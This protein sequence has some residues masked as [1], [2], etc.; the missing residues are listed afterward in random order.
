MS[1]Y[2]ETLL[3]NITI[4]VNSPPPK[5]PSSEI[6]AEVFEPIYYTNA[7]TLPISKDDTKS[8]IST[9]SKRTGFNK[10]LIKKYANRGTDPLTPKKEY[11]FSNYFVNSLPGLLPKLANLGNLDQAS[12]GYLQSF[13]DFPSG[14]YLPPLHSIISTPYFPTASYRHC[15][16]VLNSSL[17]INPN[18]T[19]YLW[20]SI[21]EI[22]DDRTG[23]SVN[24]LQPRPDGAVV[25]TSQPRSAPNPR[26]PIWLYPTTYERTIN[27]NNGQEINAFSLVFSIVPGCEENQNQASPWSITIQFGEVTLLINEG[28]PEVKITIGSNEPMNMTIQP[29]AAGIFTHHFGER[30]Y[31]LTFIPVWNGLIISDA[32]PGS[33]NWGDRVAYVPKD[34]NSNI[35]DELNKVFFPEATRH[36]PRP[37]PLDIPVIQTLRSNK[38][39]LI[40]GAL[41]RETIR[42][43]VDTTQP[44]RVIYHRCGGALKFVPVYFPQNSRYHLQMRGLVD[45]LTVPLDQ[46]II[47]SSLTPT[48]PSNQNSSTNYPFD[49]F[50]LNPIQYTQALPVISYSD[51]PDFDFRAIYANLPGSKNF[52]TAIMSVEFHKNKPDYRRPIQIWGAI[53]YRQQDPYFSIHNDEGFLT[54][55]DVPVPRILSVAIR[56]SFD[57]ASGTLVWDRYDPLLNTI[58][59]P[60]Q[61]AGALTISVQGGNDTIPGTIFTG[62]GIGNAQ[63]NDSE[64]NHITIDLFGREHKM[65][66]E[67]GLRL[68]NV[69]FFDGFDHADVMQFLC[70]YAGVPFKN[71]ALPYRLPSSF[72]LQEPIVDFASGTAI[73]SAMNEV[74]KLSNTIFYFDRTG[75]FVYIDAYNTTGVNWSYPDAVVSGF[76][77]KPDFTNLRNVIV[78]SGLVAD[79][80]FLNLD[81]TQQVTNLQLTSPVLMTLRLKTVPDFPW[82]RMAHLPINGVFSTQGEFN[83]VAYQQAAAIVRPRASGSTRIPGNATIEILDTFNENWVV[84]SINHSVDT[85]RKTFT[86]E[87]GLEFMFPVEPVG[88]ATILPVA[89]LI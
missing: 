31:I 56:R 44:L 35:V 81:P 48:P 74:T 69:P 15:N 65:S 43:H 10:C 8:L 14:V 76:E 53:L 22:T 86:T 4:A 17:N 78:L 28:K 88:T 80:N 50:L 47:G 25:M 89:N 70:D 85:Q 24:V 46:L 33:P 82:D 79:K 67:G 23:R 71:M 58:P 83:R 20:K 9:A 87:L 62:L 21:E 6:P 7:Q 64:S 12:E 32:P 84:T 38:K 11:P 36:L 39:Y 26:L 2:D 16:G 73:L 72:N 54:I 55:N 68:I 13:E 60:D 5:D 1:A 75:T 52:P 51:A 77:D 57:G 63:T 66:E 27:I 41:I 34:F 3:P 59:R 37:V 42:T 18:Q 49:P 45:P 30:P 29:S 61:R 40:P 19:T